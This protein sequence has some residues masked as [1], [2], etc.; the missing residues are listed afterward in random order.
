[1][2]S[3][4]T[5]TVVTLFLATPAAEVCLTPPL[6]AAVVGA[7]QVRTNLGGG[8]GA[9]RVHADAAVADVERAAGVQV[10]VVEAVRQGGRCRGGAGGHRQGRAVADIERARGR[11]LVDHAP[12][13]DVND[14]TADVRVSKRV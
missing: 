13:A 1:M 7:D 12:G 8:A 2:P 5:L 3:P 6:A 4:L 10:D 11:E 9:G 14:A